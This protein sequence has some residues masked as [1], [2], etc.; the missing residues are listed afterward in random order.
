MAQN[1]SRAA[2]ERRTGLHV[3]PQGLA[4]E[5][6]EKVASAGL[7]RELGL[8]ALVEVREVLE[9]AARNAAR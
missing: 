9:G 2:L 6:H 7:V 8:L 3:G 4:L 1:A 5:L